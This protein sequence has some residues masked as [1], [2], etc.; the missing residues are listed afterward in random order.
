MP[1]LDSEIF[2]IR[3]AEFSGNRAEKLVLVWMQVAV[4]H[5]DMKKAVHDIAEKSAVVMEEAVKLTGVA[6][7]T[8]DILFGE[9]EEPADILLFSGRDLE[10]F[11]ESLDLVARNDPVRLRHLGAKRNHAH[12]KNDLLVMTWTMVQGEMTELV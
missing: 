7:I 5:G 1:P 4:R 12:G 3:E 6:F 2:L 10:D 9:I 8:R 11:L